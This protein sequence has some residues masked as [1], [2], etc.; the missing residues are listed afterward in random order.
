MRPSAG[1]SLSDADARH[2]PLRLYRYA[3]SRPPPT[4]RVKSASGLDGGRFRSKLLEQAGF[5]PQHGLRVM[6]A[7]VIRGD[8]EGVLGAL[9]QGGDLGRVQVNAVPEEHLGD[10][11]QLAGAI[12]GGDGKHVVRPF[13]IRAEAHLR[14]IGR[15]HV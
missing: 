5:Q 4:R 12:A 10:T 15:A 14:E 6:Q 3:V 11:R 1:Y 13:L 7:V 2:A 9:A 8:E